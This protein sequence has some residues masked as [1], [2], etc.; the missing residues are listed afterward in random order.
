MAKK[1]AK[2]KLKRRLLGVGH[3]WYFKAPMNDP[4]QGISALCLLDV[5]HGTPQLLNT[6]GTGAWQK[7]KV[8]LEWY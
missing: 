4:P 7:V 3:P 5:D 6:C 2:R 1:K 8:Y